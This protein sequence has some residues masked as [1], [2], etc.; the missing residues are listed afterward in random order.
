MKYLYEYDFSGSC[1]PHCSN[2]N[3]TTFSVGI[4]QWIP[5]KNG[6]KK[7]PA[8][9]RIYGWSD[10]PGEVYKKALEICGQ[11]KDGEYKGKKFVRVRK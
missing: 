2:S 5:A 8:I 9:V 1:A 10:R 6:L 3:Y 4:F 7:S 11:L